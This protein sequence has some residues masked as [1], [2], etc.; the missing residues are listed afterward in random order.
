MILFRA[1]I[2]DYILLEAPSV[3]VHRGNIVLII[4][5]DRKSSKLSSLLAVVEIV[6][7]R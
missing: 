2:G 6:A 4:R 1:R 7:I 3:H 5:H